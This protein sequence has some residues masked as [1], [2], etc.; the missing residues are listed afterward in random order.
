M[1]S[2]RTGFWRERVHQRSYAA[3]D[4]TITSDRFVLPDLSS[5]R[6]KA[7]AARAGVN[8]SSRA[9]IDAADRKF[10]AARNPGADGTVPRP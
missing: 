1:P 10:A 4:R 5:P 8:L 6:S 2:E 7:A 3:G 9:S